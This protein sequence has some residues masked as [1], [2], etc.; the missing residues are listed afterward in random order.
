MGGGVEDLD[1]AIAVSYLG[2]WRSLTAGG[3][4]GFLWGV[5]LDKERVPIRPERTGCATPVARNAAAFRAG[6]ACWRSSAARRSCAE[7]AASTAARCSDDI[8]GISGIGL[9]SGTRGSGW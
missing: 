1:L 8:P 7:R 5:G 3:G 6:A 4:A 2:A 9:N